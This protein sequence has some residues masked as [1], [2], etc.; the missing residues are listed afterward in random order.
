MV[1]ELDTSLVDIRREASGDAPQISRVNELAFERTAEADVIIKLRQT[2]P[3]FISLVAVA[4]EQIIGHIL[5]TP[6]W[7][8]SPNLR[9][10]GMGLAPLAVLPENQNRGVGGM[11]I[12]AGLME[13]KNLGWPFVIVLGHPGYYPRF[14]FEPAS[15][16]GILCEYDGVPDEAF[17]ILLFDQGAIPGGRCRS[18]PV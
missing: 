6:A 11:L 1:I 13:I 12:Q 2:C 5:F 7:L 14:G 10:D 18:L 3:N 4:D 9:V 17:M 15:R 16:Y 8:E